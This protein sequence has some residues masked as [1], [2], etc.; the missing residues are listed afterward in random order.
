MKAES[1]RVVLMKNV[2]LALIRGSTSAV[3]WW[4]NEWIL[5]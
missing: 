4:M 2:L 5:E 3:N 1:E